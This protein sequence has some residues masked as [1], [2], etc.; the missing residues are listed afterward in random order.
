MVQ[1]QNKDVNFTLF[2]RALLVQQIDNSFFFFKKIKINCLYS[3]IFVVDKTHS[4]V[5]IVYAN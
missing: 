1:S 2:K 4:T 5:H 3:D